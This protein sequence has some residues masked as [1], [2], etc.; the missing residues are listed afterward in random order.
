[1]ESWRDCDTAATAEQIPTRVAFPWSWAAQSRGQQS[2]ENEPARATLN[3]HSTRH[4][5]RPGLKHSPWCTCGP[6]AFLAS[7]STRNDH[8]QS[9][10]ACQCVITVKIMQIPNPS[11]QT[12]ADHAG[13]DAIQQTL[14]RPRRS[15]RSGFNLS[16]KI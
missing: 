9:R 14:S 8:G 3:A 15:Y 13:A 1:M 6:R 16:R 12:C 10:K 2:R 7:E 5:A 4:G 11:R